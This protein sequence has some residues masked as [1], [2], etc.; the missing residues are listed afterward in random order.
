MEYV[1]G[2]TLDSVM[3]EQPSLR[4]SGEALR[5]VQDC[6]AALDY[7]HSRGVVHRDIKP[8]N[9]MLQADGVVKIADFGIAKMLPILSAHPDRGHYGI[10][11]IHGA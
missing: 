9:I 5:I 10:A 7:A 3:R 8:A 4:S 1:D 6:A 2:R 11:R